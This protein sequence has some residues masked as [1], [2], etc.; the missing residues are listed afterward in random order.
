MLFM[1]IAGQISEIYWNHFSALTLRMLMFILPHIG[2]PYFLNP[3]RFLVE[4]N[5]FRIYIGPTCAGTQSITAFTGLFAVTLLMLKK[6][7]IHIKI[8]RACFFYCIGFILAYAL[9]SLRVLLILLVGAL[10][11]QQFAITLFHNAIGSIL[12]LIFFVIYIKYALRKIT[13]N[14]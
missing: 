1:P 9:N 10:Y 7:N 4:L 8:G 13:K 3:S 12:F 14:E 2:L 6:R 11:D 5:H